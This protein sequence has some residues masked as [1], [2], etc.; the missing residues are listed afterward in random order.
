M[1]LVALFLI[2]QCLRA[3]T[4]WQV[5]V[6]PEN[7]YGAHCYD[8]GRSRMVF[9]GW[10]GDTYEKQPSAGW[11]WVSGGAPSFGGWF[12]GMAYDRNRQ[13]VVVYDGVRTW[14]WDGVA[15]QLRQ[16]PSN[17]AFL[18]LVAHKKRGTVMAF[19][20]PANPW[21]ANDLYEWNGS[22]WILVPTT[23]KPPRPG[24]W[25]ASVVY[26]KSVYDARRDKLV[27][28]GSIWFD[29]NSGQYSNLQPVIWEWDA[30]NGWV[31]RNVAGSIDPVGQLH[32]DSQRGV[33][34]KVQGIPVQ[35][36]EWDGGGG[37]IPITPT[38]TPPPGFSP[39]K[40]GAFEAQE[41]LLY[42]GFGDSNTDVPYTYGSVNPGTFTT[43]AP[44][45][46]GTLGQPTLA[47][48][49]NWTRAWMGRTLS[50]D[51]HNL[52]QSTGFLVTGWSN[53]RVG[54]FLLPVGLA[55]FGMPGCHARVSTDLIVPV[56]GASNTAT[57]TLP[58]PQNSALLGATLYQQGFAIDPAAN[59]AGLTAS[60]AVRVTIG[61]L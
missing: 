8:E 25:S 46:P 34:T 20:G 1:F 37:W 39:Y 12:G 3:Q 33:V 22:N 50:V 60:N 49:D 26:L 52:P 29:W 40:Y 2:G 47:L 51:L 27:L 42:M 32:F 5:T 61:R 59:A 16:P 14:H 57:F 10:R 53:Q 7:G 43:L 11:S 17:W 24:G 55:T 30:I 23:N 48:T 35:T 54:A 41:G 6:T 45:C 13:R 31:S 4:A 18:H 38:S 36:Y 19:G 44:G 28:Y 21:T 56:A 15:W 9:V 58:V